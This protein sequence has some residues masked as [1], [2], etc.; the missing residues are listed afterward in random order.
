MAN[1]IYIADKVTL[2][3]VKADTSIIKTDTSTIKADTST[4]KANIGT[5]GTN[6]LNNGSA[7][8]GVKS[9]TAT[10]NNNVNTANT[11]I[12]TAN[13]GINAVKA[14]IANVQAD[15]DDLQASATT[16]KANEATVIANV[17]TLQSTANNVLSNTGSIL[18][19]VGNVSSSVLNVNNN[20][21]GVKSDTATI[22]TRVAKWSVNKVTAV[23]VVMPSLET[24]VNALSITGKGCL[25]KAI[26]QNNT[27]NVIRI[28]VDGVV[29]YLSLASSTIG[30]I[31]EQ[32]INSMVNVG[33]AYNSSMPVYMSSGGFSPVG[34]IQS[35]GY[36]S[37][38]GTQ[39]TSLLA[40]PIEFGTSLSI[41]FKSS[42]T[43][44]NII[45]SL[46]YSVL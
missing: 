9:D 14:Q 37:T 31:E 17:A 30:V 21:L 11:N 7:I 27:S 29:T 26:G 5:V 22:L 28:T 46:N 2:D 40:V 19:S 4:L 43:L 25:R 12:N 16:I 6:V 18:T 23:Q 45:L 10:I 13:T 32:L 35:A 38:N 20:I 34:A 8:T 44:S 15:T 41:D 39:S 3:S 24:W 42:T 33:G 1:E 36:P